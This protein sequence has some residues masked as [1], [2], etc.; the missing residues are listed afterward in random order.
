MHGPLA[1][2]SPLS[3]LYK[4]PSISDTSRAM[5]AMAQDDVNIPRQ[6]KIQRIVR[7]SAKL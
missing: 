3:E 1:E 6:T 7:A 5:R 2:V 4:P